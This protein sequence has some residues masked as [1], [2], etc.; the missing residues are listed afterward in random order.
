MGPSTP[1]WLATVYEY[2]L[3]GTT[4]F[5]RSLNYESLGGEVEVTSVVSTVPST[6]LYLTTGAVSNGLLRWTSNPRFT[7][8][9][10]ALPRTLEAWVYLD[11]SYDFT[12]GQN[13]VFHMKTSM[14]MKVGNNAEYI[15]CGF[16]PDMAN[17]WSSFNTHFAGTYS[18]YD[19]WMHLSC[20]FTASTIDFGYNT[21]FHSEPHLYTLVQDP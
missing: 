7:D 14:A 9:Y 1:T 12:S 2:S 16:T 21:A 18:Q 17:T 8:M 11:S 13:W 15:G 5:S 3:G 20:V 19:A 4:L 10:S 6:R